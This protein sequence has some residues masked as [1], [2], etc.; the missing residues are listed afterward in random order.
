[1]YRWDSFAGSSFRHYTTFFSFFFYFL[2]LSISIFLSLPFSLPP[3]PPPPSPPP[4][5]PPPL[6]LPPLSIYFFLFIFLFSLVS[7]TSCDL[8]RF[9]EQPPSG[10]I[11]YSAS[12]SSRL[13]CIISV[14]GRSH[15]YPASA[16]RFIH[17]VVLP[18]A[19]DFNDLVSINDAI[20]LATQSLHTHHCLTSLSN[21]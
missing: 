7:F 1:M 8:V 6:A 10:R 14:A 15:Q 18:S 5:S 12:Q 19:K 11:H 9:S 20:A 21:I 3:S 13:S 2:P 17:L 16:G 4:P